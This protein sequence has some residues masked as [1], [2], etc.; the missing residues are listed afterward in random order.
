MSQPLKENFEIEI[1]TDFIEEPHADINNPS[2]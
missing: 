2:G 1:I